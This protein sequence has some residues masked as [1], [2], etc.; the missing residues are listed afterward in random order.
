MTASA[1][2]RRQPEDLA[3][4]HLIDQVRCE[5]RHLL[6][7]RLHLGTV[8][9]IGGKPLDLGRDSRAPV[10][11]RGRLDQRGANRFGITHL[12]ADKAQCSFGTVIETNVERASHFE[13]VARNVLQLFGR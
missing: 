5:F 10:P 1:L 6:A 9:I 3:P 8:V 12:P 13:I 11:S 7:N 2:G 4:N